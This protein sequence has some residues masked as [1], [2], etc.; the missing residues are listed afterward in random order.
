MLG[1]FLLL[2][3]VLR[4]AHSVLARDR[5]EGYLCFLLACVYLNVALLFL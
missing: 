4:L 1:N 3:E 2:A 5:K